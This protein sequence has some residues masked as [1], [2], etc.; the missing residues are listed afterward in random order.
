[1]PL[2]KLPWK[3]EEY[4]ILEP[5]DLKPYPAPTPEQRI[6]VAAAVATL[7]RDEDMLG[8]K[9]SG[10]NSETIRAVLM[11]SPEQWARDI[12]H[13]RACPELLYYDNVSPITRFEQVMNAGR[14]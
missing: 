13:L 7:I 2:K 5:G 3:I 6:R 8:K 9:P 10:P 12:I 14:N 1:M 4:A 11:M